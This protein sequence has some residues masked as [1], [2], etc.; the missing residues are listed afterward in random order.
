MA[1]Y[2]I[3]QGYDEAID[4]ICR[5]RK[6]KSADIYK[7]ENIIRY[8]DIYGERTYTDGPDGKYYE[9]VILTMKN[10]HGYF[11]NIDR[12]KIYEDIRTGRIAI[13]LR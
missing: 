12:R 6:C 3:V 1:D 8:N 9:I 4:L 7:C 13:Q 5:M 2:K 10:E 11:P